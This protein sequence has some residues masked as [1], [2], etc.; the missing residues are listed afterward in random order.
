MNGKKSIF[1][2]VTIWGSVV[3]VLAGAAQLFGYTIS[4]DDQAALVNLIQSGVTVITSV[5]TI[6]GGLIAIWGR[7]RATKRIAAV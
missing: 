7:V 4:P 1:S 6:A 3:A 2:S 5:V